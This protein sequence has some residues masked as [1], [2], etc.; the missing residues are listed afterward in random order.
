MNY[1]HAFHAGN[2]ADLMKH[3]AVLALLPLLRK[4]RPLWVVDTHAGAGLYDLEDP[5]AMRSKEA[6]AGILTLLGGDVPEALLP[7]AERVRAMMARFDGHKVYPGSPLLIGTSLRTDDQYVGY[8][9]DEDVFF[10]LKD[11]LEPYDASTHCKKGDGFEGAMRLAAAFATESLDRDLFV[12]ID[13]PYERGDD[14]SRLVESVVEVMIQKPDA[15]QLIWAPFKDRET[16]D[17]LIRRFEACGLT[18]DV[19]EA[20]LQDPINPMKMNGSVLIGIGLPEAGLS[21]IHAISQAVVARLGTETGEARHW[22]F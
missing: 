17:A 10:D 5:R 7:L 2:F 14:Y 19:F 20:R 13:P 16:L 6:E 9:L 8:E 11:T 1:R 4:K 18:G 12:L 15:S 3:A 22:R 21:Q